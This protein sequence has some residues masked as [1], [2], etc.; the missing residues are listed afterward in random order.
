VSTK[1]KRTVHITRVWRIAP[2]FRVLRYWAVCLRSADPIPKVALTVQL[3]TS[4]HFSDGFVR[5]SFGAGK[6]KE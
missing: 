5:S 2:S 4:I 3:S 6:L 1:P